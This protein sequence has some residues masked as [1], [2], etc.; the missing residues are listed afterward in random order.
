MGIYHYLLPFDVEDT[1]MDKFWYGFISVLSYTGY[2]ILFLVYI[3][4]FPK[5][6]L[7]TNNNNL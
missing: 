7:E 4:S 3:I 2:L 6:L 1:L 5:G